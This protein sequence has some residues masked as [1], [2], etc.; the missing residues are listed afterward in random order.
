MFRNTIFC[1]VVIGLTFFDNSDGSAQVS[2]LSMVDA[3]SLR[4]QAFAYAEQIVRGDVWVREVEVFESVGGAK[5]NESQGIII[6][7][8]MY[9]RS[10]FDFERER[11]A[12][13]RVVDQEWESVSEL[14]GNRSAGRYLYGVCYDSEKKKDVFQA[15]MPGGRSVLARNSFPESLMAFL[16]H[17]EFRDCRTTFMSLE[18]QPAMDFYQLALPRQ[19]TGDSTTE[20]QR[21]GKDQIEISTPFP[22]ASIPEGWK[23]IRERQLERFDIKSGFRLSI[24]MDGRFLNPDG[25]EV[26][27]R[28]PKVTW[29]VDWIG[30]IPVVIAGHYSSNEERGHNGSHYQ[31]ESRRNYDFHWIRLNEQPEETLFDPSNLESAEKILALVDPEKVGAKKLV[32]RPSPK[33]EPGYDD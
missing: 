33:I 21:V 14:E 25:V 24:E 13:Y 16:R 20:I 10:V 3:N 7:N 23:V 31:G 9:Y 4:D 22:S 27:S 11:F 2:E 8:T 28:S 5:D 6:E 15:L 12:L 18:S 32:R 30:E 29:K 17:I 19:L 26:K 1:A